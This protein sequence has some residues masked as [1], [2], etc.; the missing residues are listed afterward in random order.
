MSL[1]EQLVQAVEEPD[2]ELA[3][4][5][6]ARLDDLTKPP[7]SMGRLEELVRWLCL[8]RGS[9]ELEQPRPAVA[10]FA[11]DHGVAL[12]G[13]SPYPREV[14]A[15]MVLNFLAGGA[16]INAL[17]GQAGAVVKVVDVGVDA[18]FEDPTGLVQAKVARGTANFLEGPAM[19]GEECL[20]ALE[21]GARVAGDLVDEGHDLLVPGDMGIGNTTASSALAAVFTGQPPERVTGRGTGLDD[22]GLARKVEVIKQ[23]LD[24]HRPDPARPLEVLQCLGGL[25]IAAIC[26]FVLAAAGRRVPVILDGLISVAGAM[27]ASRLC[28]AV[29]AY[30]QAGHASV[31]VGQGAMLAEMGLRPLLD[32]DLRLGDGTGGALALGLVRSAVAMYNQMATFASAGVSDREG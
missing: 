28:P 27:V 32:L 16:C 3:P 23:A 30:L 13:V 8:A 6:Q 25:E 29:G 14:T 26:G 2:Q 9:L 17:A 12:S 22:Q 21:V 10:V 19:T 1:L 7:G 18:D 31:E 5:V 24:R 11:A 15:Q 20:Q 4:R